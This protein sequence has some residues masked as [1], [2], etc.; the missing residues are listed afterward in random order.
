MQ[1]V[2]R[3]ETHASIIFL[4][5]ALAYKLKRAVRYPYLDYSSAALRRRFCEAELEVNRRTAPDIYRR[6]V[7]VVRLAGGGLALGGD[8]ELRSTG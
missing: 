5:G 6:V 2:E 4:A 7:P 3:R 8:T 1:R